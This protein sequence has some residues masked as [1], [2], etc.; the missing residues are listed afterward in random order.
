MFQ[1]LAVLDLQSFT[2]EEAGEGDSAL[3]VSSADRLLYSLDDS[4]T[5][6]NLIKEI[7]FSPD[8]RLLCSPHGFGF[9][10]LAF[11][12]CMGEPCD[13]ISLH[14]PSPLTEVASIYAH[15]S[16]VVAAKFSPTEPLVA[17]A[18]LQS[19]IVFSHPR[20]N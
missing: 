14:Y 17:S 3:R 11:S 12:D 10:L 9:R 6:S 16:A 18:C 5:E 7:D 1:K 8:G 20:I 4:S 2:H 19:K 13:N 15:K